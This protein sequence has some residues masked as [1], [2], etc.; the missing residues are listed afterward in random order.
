MHNHICFCRSIKSCLPA[1]VLMMVYVLIKTN[2]D[3]EIDLILNHF[4]QNYCEWKEEI[5]IDF[6]LLIYI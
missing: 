4:D 6:V 2:N 1:T 5:D 3:S